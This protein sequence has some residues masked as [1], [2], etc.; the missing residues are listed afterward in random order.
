MDTVKY[1]LRWLAVLPGAI[2]GGFLMTFPLHWILYNTLSNFIEPYP[3]LPERTLTP[4]AVAAG[5]VWSGARIAP[6]QKTEAAVV[7]FGVWLMF[8]TAMLALVLFD[9]PL[10]GRRLFFYGRGLSFV[11]GL[12]G[13]IIGLRLVRN[14]GTEPKSVPSTLAKSTPA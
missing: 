10:S 1:W 9:I 5:F 2:L 14:E 13:A 8:L 11:A 3:A 6:A 12:A 4:L 7:L